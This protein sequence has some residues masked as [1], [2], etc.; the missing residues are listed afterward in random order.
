MY[1]AVGLMLGGW[2]IGFESRALTVYAVFVMLPCHLR[3]VLGEEL[4]G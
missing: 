4:A 3:V 1:I 2:A